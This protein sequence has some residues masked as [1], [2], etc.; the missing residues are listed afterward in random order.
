MT[1]QQRGSTGGSY[2][3]AAQC[4]SPDGNVTSRRS[5]GEA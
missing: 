2:S 3:Q 4:E 5:I 1:T